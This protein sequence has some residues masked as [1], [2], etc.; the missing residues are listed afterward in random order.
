M[1]KRLVHTAKHTSGSGTVHT[2]KV[3][4]CTEWN[5]WVV[6]FS[7]DNHMLKKSDY[8]AS[9]KQ[10]AIETADYHIQRVAKQFA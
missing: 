7:V 2:A 4:R 1:A 3:Y 10:D 8:H 6:V 5:E 9:D